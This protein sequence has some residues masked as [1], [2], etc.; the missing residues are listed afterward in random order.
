ME[1]VCLSGTG[2]QPAVRRCGRLG[3]LRGHVCAH[4]PIAVSGAPV[5]FSCGRSLA[6]IPG[7][8]GRNVSAPGR[9]ELWSAPHGAQGGQVTPPSPTPRLGRLQLQLSEPWFRHHVFSLQSSP[10]NVP[11]SFPACQSRAPRE[12]PHR[13]DYPF[14]ENSDVGNSM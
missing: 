7:R 11:L 5:G 1:G 12:S 6:S 3:F 2:P 4:A 13:S 10:S 14:L 9:L 8:E